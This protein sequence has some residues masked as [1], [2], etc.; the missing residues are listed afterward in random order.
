MAVMG[1]QV[2]TGGNVIY[3]RRGFTHDAENQEDY[4]RQL[5]IPTPRLCPNCRHY[6][7]LKKTN[8]PKLWHRK[9]MKD[10]CT[11]EFE[12]SYTPDRPEIVYCEEHYNAEIL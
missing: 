5:G 3:T 4:Y 6:E 12:T 11:T 10:G 1:K 7:R 8:P 9:C 2:V